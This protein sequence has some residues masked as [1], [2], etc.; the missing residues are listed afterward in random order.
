MKTL[1]FHRVSLVVGLA[2]AIMVVWSAAAPSAEDHAS[3]I[4]G[5]VGTS[6]AYCCFN[7]SPCFCDQ[8]TGIWAGCAHDPQVCCF[9]AGTPTSKNCSAKPGTDPCGSGGLL[10]QTIHDAQCT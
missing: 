2:L 8:G 7:T 1:S 5:W 9:W 4:G 3:W 6:W 10:C